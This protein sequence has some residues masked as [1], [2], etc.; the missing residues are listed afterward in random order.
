MC[1]DLMY[2]LGDPAVYAHD[3]LAVGFLLDLL[4]ECRELV[5]VTSLYL[6]DLAAEFVEATVFDA[7][8]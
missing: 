4:G 8:L 5:L 3:V 6:V 1:G 7:R 2:L